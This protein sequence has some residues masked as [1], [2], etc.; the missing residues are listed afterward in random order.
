MIVLND[1][2]Y[3]FHLNGFNGSAISAINDEL[4]IWRNKIERHEIVINV[5]AICFASVNI[6]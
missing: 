3:I 1:I 5:S 6:I 2:I 4:S